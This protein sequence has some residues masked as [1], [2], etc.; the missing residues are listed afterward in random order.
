MFNR[1]RTWTIADANGL[2]AEEFAEKLTQH[3][4]TLCQ[5][6]RR[7][8]VVYLNDSLSE[9]GAGEWALVKVDVLTRDRLGGKQFESVTFGW[10]DAERGAEYV[11]QY[12]DP[13]QVAALLAEY[14]YRVNAR[15]H[16]PSERC[17]LCA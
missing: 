10:V 8:T 3:S 13:E 2:T 7:G 1:N 16:E 11:R 9:D 17:Q 12:D 15:V 5:G 6:W 14:G 4:W